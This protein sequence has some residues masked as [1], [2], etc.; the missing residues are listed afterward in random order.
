MKISTIGLSW[1][2]ET[3]DCSFLKEEEE[4]EEES[5]AVVCC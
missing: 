4:E 1:M 3:M 5:A 2:D